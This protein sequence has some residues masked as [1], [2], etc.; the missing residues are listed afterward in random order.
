MA[1]TPA[2]ATCPECLRRTL[3][4]AEQRLQRAQAERDEVAA[5]LARAGG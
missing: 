2:K 3:V 1:P 4:I 5:A